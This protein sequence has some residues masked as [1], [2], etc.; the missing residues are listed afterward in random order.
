MTIFLQ[1][2]GTSHCHLC[3]HAEIQLTEL[4]KKFD[5]QWCVTEITNDSKL[6]ELYELKIPVLRRMDNNMEIE[7]PFNLYEM[8]QLIK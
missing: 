5:I 4:S 6:L 3:E 1:L 7:W 8:I 2:Y